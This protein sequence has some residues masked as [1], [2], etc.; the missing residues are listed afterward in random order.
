MSPSHHRI[1]PGST[2]ALP[3]AAE[4]MLG[5]WYATCCGALLKRQK[6][7]STGSAPWWPM[8]LGR[9][10]HRNN[11]KRSS[12]TSSPD[13]GQSVVEVEFSDTAE[14]D[15]VEIDE[16]GIARFGEHVV[17]S[18]ML[19]FNEASGHLGVVPLTAP[20]R[21]ELGENI[22][23]LVRQRDRILYRAPE[24]HALILRIP[25]HIGDAPHTLTGPPT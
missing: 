20:R 1:A 3:K 23:C 16:F 22:H 2:T 19:G 4:P 11:A 5:I 6:L 17:K 18:C 15:L 7:T 21:P 24:F 8:H 9:T 10:F 12:K 13:A 14:A 25:Y